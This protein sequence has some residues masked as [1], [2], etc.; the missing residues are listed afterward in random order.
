MWHTENGSEENIEEDRVEDLE[1]LCDVDLE[2]YYGKF[3]KNWNR[4]RYV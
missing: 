4:I 3:P 1:I 2:K